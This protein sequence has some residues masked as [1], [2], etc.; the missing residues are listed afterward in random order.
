MK[1]NIFKTPAE[2]LC[3]IGKDLL[4]ESEFL[5]NEI[6][7][8][9]EED[10]KTKKN[11]QINKV[12]KNFEIFNKMISDNEDLI[13]ECDNLMNMV[14]EVYEKLGKLKSHIN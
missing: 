8:L 6:D 4:K 10:L 14:D 1:N 3:N 12:T 7:R 5:N 2:K 9:E 13:L 11:E